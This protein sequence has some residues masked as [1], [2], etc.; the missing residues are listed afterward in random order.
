[1]KQGTE[2]LR[3]FDEVNQAL[4]QLTAAKQSLLAEVKQLHE[5]L[6]DLLAV[7]VV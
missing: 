2:Y 4:T 7:E 6:D 1:M 3:K 5:V